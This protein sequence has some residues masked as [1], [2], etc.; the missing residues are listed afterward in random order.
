M[1]RLKNSIQDLTQQEKTKRDIDILET[2]RAIEEARMMRD[3][4]HRDFEREMEQKQLLL[5]RVILFIII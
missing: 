4:K 5:A 2:E 3:I 1:N